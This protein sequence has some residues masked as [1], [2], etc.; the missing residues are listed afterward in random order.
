MLSFLALVAFGTPAVGLI[1]YAIWRN[2][3]K[4]DI[5]SDSPSKRDWYK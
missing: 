4:N 3:G 5:K 1:G 2:P